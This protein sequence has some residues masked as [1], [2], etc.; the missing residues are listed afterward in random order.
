[1]E[2]FLQADAWI[3]L[4]TLTFLEI[5]LGI[6]NI[7]FISIVSNKLEEKDRPKARNIGLLLAMFFRIGLLFGIS[8]VL[9]LQTVL[10]EIDTSWL[11]AGI[12]GQSL[13]ILA[14]GIFLLY[15][16][17]AEIH[18]KLEGE[19]QSASSK[20]SKTITSAIIQIVMLDLVFSFDSVL[21]AIG[22]VSFDAAPVGFGYFGGMAIIITAI[23]ISIIIMLVFAGPVSKFVNEHPTIQILGLSFLILIGVML[24]AE[25]SHLAHFEF[26]GN[27]VHS[28]PKGYLYFAIFFSL[29][30]E[31]IN[32]RMKKGKN[33]VVLKNSTI[34]DDKLKDTKIL[35]K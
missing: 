4:L 24:L 31:F 3:A 29:F 18:H 33:P 21:T 19:E 28:I 6:D 1:M 12:T 35:D 26:F 11:K 9:R 23:I 25:G 20:A 16:S 27:A 17:V 32:L 10:F 34:I 13:I 14:G 8:W 2:I 22:L 15:K 5:V 7:V 30:V